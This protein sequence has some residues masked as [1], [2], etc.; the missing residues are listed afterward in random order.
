MK[1]PD[2]SKSPSTSPNS[3]E[4]TNKNIYIAPKKWSTN[5]LINF[6]E[7]FK[8]I[9]IL[10]EFRNDSSLLFVSPPEV[11]F[12]HMCINFN[13]IFIFQ[14]TTLLEWSCV[15]ACVHARA[16]QIALL[17]AAFALM[18]PCLNMDWYAVCASS[19]RLY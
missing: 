10:L 16:R 18:F 15:R 5:C 7:K 2:K 1:Q 14:L 9:Y 8:V 4:S 19:S 6:W 12:S 17:F 13:V 11:S 3:I